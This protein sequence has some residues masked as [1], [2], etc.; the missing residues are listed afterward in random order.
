MKALAHGRYVPYA[1]VAPGMVWM[2]VFF[3]LPMVFMVSLSLQQGDIISGF[4]QTW[5]VATYW[6]QWKQYDHVFLRS[7]VYGAIVVVAEIVIAFP[8]AWWIVFHA[9]RRKGVYLS[10]MLAPFVVSLV[11]RTLAWNVLLSDNGIL[12]S[13][14]K[15]M[16]LVRA[17]FHVLATPFAVIAGLTYN[18]FPFMLLPIYVALDRLDP[19][20]LDAGADLYANPATVILR[21]VVPLIMTGIFT[22]M[23]LTFVPV[24]CDYVS[25]S[26]LGGPGTTMIGNVIRTQYLDNTNYPVGSAIALMLMLVMLAV[27]CIYRYFLSARN[28]LEVSAR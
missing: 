19:R 8:V 21:V 24:C 2:A 7:I 22:G 1:L 11:I 28:V 12:L 14:L 9:G 18:F 20:L 17:D 15:D 5:H 6:D 27:V 16:H 26:M 10:L 23:L 3:V 25:A 4:H 13:A